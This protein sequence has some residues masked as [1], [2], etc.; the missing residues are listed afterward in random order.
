[1][2]PEPADV[3]TAVV[4]ALLQRENKSFMAGHLAIRLASV[5]DDPKYRF[6]SV[7]RNL[8]AAVETVAKAN[9]SQLI[10]AQ[11]IDMLHDELSS[12]NPASEFKTDFA[13][14]FPAST[15][16]AL[17]ELTPVPREI[18]QA[19]HSYTDLDTLPG[20]QEVIEEGEEQ[21]V[22]FELPQ[23]T[24]GIHFKPENYRFAKQALLFEL[25]KMG[26]GDAHVAHKIDAPNVMIYQ[27]SFVT[28]AG[29]HNVIVPI[30]VNDGIVSLPNVFGP[31]DGS[32]AYAFS[33]AGIA[34][35]AGDE[36]DLANVRAL[37][38]SNLKREAGITDDGSRGAGASESM[39]EDEVS[40]TTAG[41]EDIEDILVAASATK[42]SRYASR[43]IASAI[44]TISRELRAFNQHTKPAFVGD[45]ADGELL[46]KVRLT[47][48]NKVA[49][50]V[51]PLEVTSGIALL[52]TV[53]K[54][55]D[56]THP[57]SSASIEQFFAELPAVVSKKDEKSVI[58][59]RKLSS[60]DWANLLEAEMRSVS[61]GKTIEAPAGVTF[62]FER[63]AVPH[64]I[65]HIT[66]SHIQFT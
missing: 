52:P 30:A 54:A 38:S 48:A 15:A 12:L 66:T 11:Q 9:P 45:S 16:P 42:N 8:C 39:I 46:F 26:A 63:T 64:D 41:L 47:K 25:G 7:A 40:I 50:V 34:K 36:A 2:N 56:Q 23:Y 6:D 5:A 18:E 14:I 31:M 13:E 57:I 51:I 49:E 65:H 58:S 4:A 27:A 32:R 55:G 1:M 20:K 29:Q 53:F 60:D 21:S 37:E 17:P 19:R 22:P 44:D 59:S 10:T 28:K 43:T 3:I 62:E 35:F 61:N 33:Q 24:A